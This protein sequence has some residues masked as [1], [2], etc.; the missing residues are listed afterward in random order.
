MPQENGIN[1]EIVA[2]TEQET[3]MAE[4]HARLFSSKIVV[5][6]CN[7]MSKNIWKYC[8]ILGLLFSACSAPLQQQY[9]YIPDSSWTVSYVVKPDSL[10]P[11]GTPPLSAPNRTVIGTLPDNQVELLWQNAEHADS[12]TLWYVQ[13][14][15]YVSRPVEFKVEMNADDV[16]ALY[17]DKQLQIKIGYTDRNYAAGTVRLRTGWNMVTAA[18]WNDVGEMALRLKPLLSTQVE[19][20]ASRRIARHE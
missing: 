20:M 10:R 12:Q 17:V 16:G 4:L 6:G 5:K 8:I 18:I 13:T 19:K 1:F 9:T 15:V 3:E 2:L 7:Q 14:Y 11:D